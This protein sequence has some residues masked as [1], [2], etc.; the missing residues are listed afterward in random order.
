MRIAAKLIMIGCGLFLV[1][2]AVILAV[3]WFS[4]RLFFLGDE[5]TFLY[6]HSVEF[7]GNLMR[8]QVQHWPI[9]LEMITIVVAAP[10]GLLL[11]IAAF[12]YAASSRFVKE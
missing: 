9:T 12:L 8:I 7:D 4:G 1:V 3:G 2:L 11:T 5:L 10:I 6:R